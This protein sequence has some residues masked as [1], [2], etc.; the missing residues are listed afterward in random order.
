MMQAYLIK[1]WDLTKVVCAQYLGDLGCEH[2]VLKNDEVTVEDILAMHPRGILVS[3]GPGTAPCPAIIC[4][5]MTKTWP[6]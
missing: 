6:R 4:Y 5:G 3:P 2:I 1:S